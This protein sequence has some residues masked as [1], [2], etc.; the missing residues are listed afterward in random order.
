MIKVASLFAQVLS[1]IDRNKFTRSV[2]YLGVEKSAKGFR[3]WEQC[4][5]MLFCQLGGANSLR[6]ICGVLATAIGKVKYLGINHLPNKS[7]LSYANAV[8]VVIPTGSKMKISWL[9]L[10]RRLNLKDSLP[11]SARNAAAA[12]VATLPNR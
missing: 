9:M 8:L 5:A 6:E 11:S 3:C 4:V 12:S 2:H 1:L 10:S 7:T